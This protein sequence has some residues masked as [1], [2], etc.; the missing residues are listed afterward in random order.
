MP[1]A[2]LR[3]SRL[4]DRPGFGL[5]FKFKGLTTL[6]VGLAICG[7]LMWAPA[8]A[9]AEPPVLNERQ[10]QVFSLICA[11]CHVQ[12]GLGVPVVGDTAEWQRRSANGFDILL[13]H[14]VTGF[15]GMPPLGTCSF[16][17]EEDLRNLVAFMAR[18]PLP[19]EFEM[20]NDE[21]VQP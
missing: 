2:P 8:A 7:S 15:A 10:V 6:L 12:P 11:R 9:H 13:S 18:L 4:P 14:T 20:D 19:P 21:G 3:N 1:C 16:C 5:F 17:S